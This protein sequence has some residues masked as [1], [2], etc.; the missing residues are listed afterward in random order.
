[1]KRIISIALFSLLACGSLHAQM[2]SVAMKNWQDYMTPGPMHTMIAKYDGTFAEEIT[3]WM[4][5][6]GAA[7]KS[8]ST[9]VNKM[10][11][12]GKY[13][14]SRVTGNFGGML[15]EGYSLLGYD[16]A[17]KVFQ[18]MWIDNMG[19][20]IMLLEGPWDAATKSITFK[21]KMTDPMTGKM[22]NIRQVITFINDNEQKIEMYAD[23]YGKEF[24]SMEMMVKRK[25]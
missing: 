18:S 5:P 15:F 19:T 3:M 4:T 13:Q 11:F 10:I 20:G 24:K 6:G 8:T 25:P 22:S 21:G 23:T 7:E 14:E 12:G 17:R 1:M 2:D 9:T 16:N